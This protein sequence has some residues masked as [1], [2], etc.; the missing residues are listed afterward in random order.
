MHVF[1]TGASGYIGS[2][3][4]PELIAAGHTV[5]GLARS[6]RA[7]AA[8]AA[9]GATARRGDLADLPG[10]AAAAREADGVVHLGFARDDPG[11]G[12][13]AAAVA[14]DLRAVD[15]LGAALTGTGKPLVTTGATLSL[16]LAGFRGELT[17]HDTRPAGMRVDAENAV[18]ALAGRGVRSAVVRLPNVHGGSRLGFASGLI[19]VARATGVAHYLGD[20]AQRWPSVHIGDVGGLYRRALESAPAG[21]RLHAVAEEGVGVRAVS[22]VIGRRLGVPVAP[23]DADAARRHFGHLAMFV[24][25]DNPTSSRSTRA[26]LDWTPG[27]PGLLDDLDDPAHYALPAGAPAV[28]RP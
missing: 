12:D 15:A 7:A 3:V 16:A 14:A 22:E 13:L 6:D 28:A 2:A 17:E 18:V 21:S 10:L 9:L 26:A 8:V 1:V 25:A 11:W 4:V 19:A 5:T 24:G 27:G 20:G 23:L